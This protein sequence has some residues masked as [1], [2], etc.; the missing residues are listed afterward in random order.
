MN[1]K[2]ESIKPYIKFHLQ[3]SLGVPVADK[4]IDALCNNDAILG[5]SNVGE[6]YI[7][8]S[9]ITLEKRAEWEKK[10]KSKEEE[11]EPTN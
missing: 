10:R 9:N 2:L 4:D 5:V 11:N 3:H 1:L 8:V 6:G 7:L